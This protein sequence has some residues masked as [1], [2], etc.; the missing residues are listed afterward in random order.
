M[1]HGTLLFN[2]D[3]EKLTEC[4]KADT[5]KFKDKSVKS[6]RSQVANISEL[7]LK[8]RS[9]KV[10][11]KH[12]EQFL[13]DKFQAIPYEFKQ[14]DLLEIE[15][16]KKNKYT[17]WKWNYGYS[18]VYEFSKRKKSGIYILISKLKVEKGIITEIAIKTDHPKKEN[19][20]NILK[21]IKGTLH[22]RKSIE[23]I[24]KNYDKTILNEIMN[25]I[26]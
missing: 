9:I 26:F 6:V 18:P 4:L 5:M 19:I 3:L 15:N 2:S 14:T 21:I 11:K 23:K 10:F 8:T 12:I 1:H 22:E 16:L 25:C 17:T 20:N 24:L 13:K 7:V